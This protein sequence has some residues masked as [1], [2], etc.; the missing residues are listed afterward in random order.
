M[1]EI[2][3][4]HEIPG[5]LH[6]G[7]EEP[8]AYF[9]PFETEEKSS[10]DRENSAFFTSL[11]GEWS[12][13]FFENAARLDIEK[14]GFSSSVV[15]NDKITVPGNWQ[16]CLDRGYD[17]PNYINQD[18]PYPVDAPYIPDVV[19]CGFYRK[20][21]TLA[22]KENK[23]YFI[24]FEGVSS[25]FYL[26]VNGAFAAYS[27]VS[28][29]T[30]VVDITD[31]LIN[32]ENRFEAL[33]VKH[34]DGSYFE[35]QD[36]FRLSGI[37]R[38][39]YITE[40]DTVYIKDIDLDIKVS[41]NLKTA[42][43]KGVI[44][45]ADCFDFR[46]VSPC[47]DVVCSG[48]NSLD[49][50][51][52]N[53]LL[54]NYETPYLY[55]LFI[56]SCN[57]YI[58]LPVGFKR[59]EIKNSAVL[60][61][62]EKVKAKG[63][64]RHDFNPE[65]G[66]WV[67]PAQM[68]LELH[69]LKRANVNTIRTSH[70]PNDP[71]FLE[72]CDRLGFMVVDEADLETH[73]MGYNFGD[74]YWDYWSHLTDSPEYAEACVDRAKLLY[75][76]DK[77]H[78]CVI[79]WS[80]GNESGC[81][82]NH[83][84]MAN[85]IRS[86][87][88]DAVIHYENARLEYQ[89]RLGKDFTDISDVESR[90]YATIA[91][92]KEYL[93]DENL[94]KPFFYCEYVDSMSTGEIAKHWQGFEENDKYFGG[95]VWEY[96]DHAVNAGTKE[97]PE[98]RY[99]GDFGD[100]PNDGIYCLDGL[101]Y[102][103][104]SERPGYY[105]M[106]KVYQP[107][108]ITYENGKI[109][110][111][112]KRFFTDFSDLYIYWTVEKNG[113]VTLEGTIENPVVAP[114]GAAEYSLFE[115]IELNCLT[116]LN[117]YVRQ[118]NKTEWASEDFETGF[119][120]FILC[121]K[122]VEYKPLTD[123]AVS[124]TE[125]RTDIFIKCGKTQYSF[126][127]VTG[128]ITQIET[129]GKTLLTEPLSFKIIRA[130]TYNSKHYLEIWSRARYE[131]I[132]QKTYSVTVEKDGG[133]VVVSSKISLASPAMPPAVRAD[134]TYT[135]RSDGS[136]TVTTDA[137][138]THNAPPLPRFGLSLVLPASFS[139]VKYLGYGPKESYAERHGSARLSLYETTPSD[140]YEHYIKPQESSSHYSTRFA[141]ISDGGTGLKFYTEKPF[142]FKAIPYDDATIHNTLHDDELPASGKTF[143]SL[144]YKIH[145]SVTGEP[146]EYPERVF[147]DKEFSFTVRIVPFLG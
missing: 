113:K 145:A 21:V 69:S 3:R 65:T 72:M 142:C 51:L 44:T 32:G 62:G 47:G 129:D 52:D 43:L 12:F 106:K 103:D 102:P 14:D 92:L 33:V 17:V 112:N 105:D 13:A 9:I 27:Q 85:Y 88:K 46:L 74:W 108:E 118:K 60:L 40:R 100:Y 146:G 86:R 59:F 28:H 104:R 58:C 48:E 75:E 4:Y 144:D 115:N 107:F 147:D 45:G 82:E 38:E 18:Y 67:T 89:E 50:S 19:P 1:P 55:K 30:A 122:A 143:V 39:V 37:F 132:N 81:G 140:D 15:C 26:W 71:R 127:R 25:C 29:A 139:Q 96:G 93:A 49:V 138:V 91:Y 128:R 126:D 10:G 73:G 110:V 8:C 77:N 141:R 94:R 66:Y 6:I 131:H 109:K 83:R 20:T 70:Y 125:T 90:M 119:E 95:C 16:L 2:K 31:R 56:H 78:V 57:E 23:K 123:N 61:N 121:D 79:M 135:F 54:W 120:Q 41:E 53:P 36:F 80:L 99:G 111:L 97:K 136:V 130:A 137:K 22:K 116:T 133:N 5:A 114:R 87:R 117:V 63:I 24:N 84:K 76:R 98:Y 35:D 64:N 11:C 124:F 101:V 34:C 42:S 134:V 68:L 7:C